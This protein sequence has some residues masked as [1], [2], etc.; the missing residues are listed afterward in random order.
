MNNF[1]SADNYLSQIETVISKDR[2]IP[3]LI[4]ST[5]ANNVLAYK[6]YK[7]GNRE[8]VFSLLLDS[9]EID[10]ILEEKGFGLLHFH[11][12]QTLHNI[13]RTYLKQN[14]SSGVH[15]SLELMKYLSAKTVDFRLGKFIFLHE[16]NAF[17]PQLCRGLFLQILDDLILHFIKHSDDDDIYYLGI[18]RRNLDT[19]CQK[20]NYICFVEKWLDIVLD[21]NSNSGTGSINAVTKFL[22]S[23]N[24]KIAS[25]NIFLIKKLLLIYPFENEQ[26]EEIRSTMSSYGF[27][28]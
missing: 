24:D 25:L 27:C 10:C 5:M 14:L 6:A 8:K 21:L 15:L 7:Y 18:F 16:K 11:K 26:I 9:L 3:N 22:N 12:I 28:I 13:A 2:H 19:I 20:E 23:H 17:S 4:I 1:S